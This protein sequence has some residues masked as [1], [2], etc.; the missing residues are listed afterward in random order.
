M[1]ECDERGTFSTESVA[2]AL[3]TVPKAKLLAITGA[4]NVTGWLPP[5]EAII[6]AAHDRAIPVLVD[7]AQLVA[8]R[9]LP[10]DADYVVFSGHKMYAPFGCGVLIG[11]RSSF[12]DGD[13]FLVG[14]GAVDLVD[15][16]E[17]IWTAPPEREE[18]GSPNVIGAVALHAAINELLSIGFGAIT[19]HDDL[20]AHA[21]RS[22]LRGITGVRLL[23]PDLDTST[24]PVASFTIE[25]VSHALIAARLS[26]E[27]GIGVRHGCFCAHPYLVRLLGMRGASL[28]SFRSMARAGQRA[29]LPGA[30]RA[31][32]GLTTTLEDVDRLLHAVAEI[33]GTPTPASYVQDERNGE[34][35]PTGLRRPDE[36]MGALPGCGA[37]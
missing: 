19:A 32:G 1:V 13:P 11:P 28:E 12:T 5:I 34:W 3:D 9:A 23:G 36:G 6:T 14:G 33:A 17:V 35:W 26:A 10:A 20:V 29:A 15:L 8:H 24:L 27:F 18:A 4:S 30:V 7:A 21:L 2:A 37:T 16:D 31:S 22:G 25:G